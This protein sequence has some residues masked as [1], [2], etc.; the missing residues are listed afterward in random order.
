MVFAKVKPYF[1]YF[2][3]LPMALLGGLL[4]IEMD[5]MKFHIKKCCFNAI[6]L[7]LSMLALWALLASGVDKI[8]AIVL[9]ILI[10]TLMMY[11]KRQLHPKPD[12]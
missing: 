8:V 1:D 12:N 3:Y 4:I 7:I 9:T 2:E 5:K 10:F 6:I 11:I